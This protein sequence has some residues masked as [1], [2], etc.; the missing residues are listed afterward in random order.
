MQKY[1]KSHTCL[2]ILTEQKCILG[3]IKKQKIN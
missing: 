1:I 3:L 2:T